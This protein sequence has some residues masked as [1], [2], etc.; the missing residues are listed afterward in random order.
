MLFRSERRATD[1][2]IKELRARRNGETPK[3]KPAPEAPATPA[4]EASSAVEDIVDTVVEPEV[5]TTD[6]FRPRFAP[7]PK[8]WRK[9]PYPDSK[10]PKSGGKI[11]QEIAGTNNRANIGF[12]QDDIDHAISRAEQ[13][14]WTEEMTLHALSRN[15]KSADYKAQEE[16]VQIAKRNLD[17]LHEAEQLLKKKDKELVKKEVDDGIANFRA[18]LAE[19]RT[20]EDLRKARDLLKIGRA[21]V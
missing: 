19:A 18:T 21:H 7:Q 4:S 20:E 1:K 10:K 12:I 17:Q 14:L 8:D 6:T 13:Q 5:P 15:P 16:V 9:S 2:A 11:K 3:P